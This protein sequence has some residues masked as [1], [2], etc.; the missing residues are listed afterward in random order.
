MRDR[1]RIEISAGW[2]VLWD[3]FHRDRYAGRIGTRLERWTGTEWLPDDAR[4]LITTG[5]VLTYPG[6]GRRHRPRATERSLYRVHVEAPGYRPLYEPEQPDQPDQTPPDPW[7]D[8]GRQKPESYGRLV[9]TTAAD[10]RE[11]DVVHYDATTPPDAGAAP[12]P[13]FLPLVPAIDFAYPPG[14]RV[15]TGRVQRP[16]GAGVPGVLVQAVTSS[17]LSHGDWYERTVT[18]AGGRCRLALRWRGAV[19]EPLTLTPQRETFLV[20]AYESPGRSGTADVVIDPAEA[21]PGRPREPFVIEIA[22]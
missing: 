4:P 21:Q 19:D 11:I 9:F 14:T 1:V 13:E 22:D 5:R 12:K 10:G 20:H 6:L 2:L 15:V 17:E 7:A 16:D 3:D 8:R 18:D